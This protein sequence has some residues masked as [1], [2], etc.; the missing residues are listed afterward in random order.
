MTATE[1]IDK[2]RK[3]LP[4]PVNYRLTEMEIPIENENAASLQFE[5]PIDAPTMYD[6]PFYHVR[7]RKQFISGMVVGWEF[8][9]LY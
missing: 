7:F 5:Y 3:Q 1:I 4:D 6:K 2:A 9:G 8:E